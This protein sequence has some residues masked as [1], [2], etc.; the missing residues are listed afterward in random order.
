MTLLS[1]RTAPDGG[2]GMLL[3]GLP[4]D[5]LPTPLHRRQN[6]RTAIV[7]GIVARG[8]LKLRLPG[9]VRYSY[10]SIGIIVGENEWRSSAI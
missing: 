2:I 6:D 10:F 4:V 8:S 7:G 1:R 5:I 3:I 9:N